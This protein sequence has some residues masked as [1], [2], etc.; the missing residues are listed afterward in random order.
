VSLGISELGLSLGQETPFCRELRSAALDDAGLRRT[1]FGE[2]PFLP[3][4][5]QWSPTDYWIETAPGEGGRDQL[6]VT[7]L[8]PHRRIPL[9]RYATGDWA[10]VLTLS[11]LQNATKKIGHA[12]RPPEVPFPFVAVWGRGRSAAA[13]DGRS[14]YPE[15]VKEALYRCAGLVGITTG[16]FRIVP[17]GSAFTLRFQLRADVVATRTLLDAAEGAMARQIGRPVRLEL[18]PFAEWD[19]GVELSYQRKFQYL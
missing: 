3:T 19:G 15:E 9:I 17:G 2:A 18:V 14:V 8:D 6:V 10:R 5:V 11:D 12:L 13:G 1:L 7:T 4:F 16:S